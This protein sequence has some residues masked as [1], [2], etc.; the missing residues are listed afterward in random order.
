LTN[1]D[2]IIYYTRPGSTRCPLI[3]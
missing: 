3:Y 2:L 1:N